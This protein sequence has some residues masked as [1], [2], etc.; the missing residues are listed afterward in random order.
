MLAAQLDCPSEN[1]PLLASPSPQS[2][3]ETDVDAVPGIPDGVELPRFPQQL[4]D[5]FRRGQTSFWGKVKMVILFFI[6]FPIRLVFIIL[7]G[8]VYCAAAC[9]LGPCLPPK[10]KPLPPGL[11]AFVKFVGMVL[12]R[13]I[14]YIY[15][16]LWVKT[17]G[18]PDKNVKVL[19]ANHTSMM[20]CLYLLFVWSPAFVIADFISR[21]PV[22]KWFTRFQQCVVV[23]RGKGNNSDALKERVTNPEWPPVMIFPE[24]T[25]NNGTHL[26]YFHTGAFVNGCPIQPVVISYPYWSFDPSWSTMHGAFNMLGLLCQ[27]FNQMEIAYLPVYHP[28]EAERLDPRLYARNVRA[29]IAAYGGR[30]ITDLAYKDKCKYE[31][32]AEAYEKAGKSIPQR[33]PQRRVAYPTVPADAYNVHMTRFQSGA[34]RAYLD[35]DQAAIMAT[36]IP[37]VTP[38]TSPSSLQ[39]PMGPLGSSA[40]LGPSPVQPIPLHLD[41]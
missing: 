9:I 38:P 27:V 34:D 41:S 15:G 21:A 39:S 23:N 30:P 3:T 33:T 1:M 18:K 6:L 4:V 20:D 5:V 7:Y 11:R 14:L 16:F 8:L 24:G 2:S 19:V 37:S 40:L 17:K 35:T 12:G 31:E 28:S 32:L 22:V 29:V 26:A 36:P 25:T 10:T 13:S